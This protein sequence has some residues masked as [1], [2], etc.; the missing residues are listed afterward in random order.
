M[1]IS[2]NGVK[3]ICCDVCRDPLTSVRIGGY[4]TYENFGFS[5]CSGCCAKPIA[6]DSIDKKMVQFFI[7]FYNK[8]K[9][10]KDAMPPFWPI[11]ADG[12]S[13]NIQLLRMIA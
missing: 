13:V 2:K 1:Q 3:I 9:T 10:I 5:V 8:T 12:L 7:A 4:Q 6:I 11:D